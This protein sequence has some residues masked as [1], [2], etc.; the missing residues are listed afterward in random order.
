MRR[1]R[2]GR[3]RLG[4]RMLGS[5]RRKRMR[6]RLRLCGG[7][8]HRCWLERRPQHRRSTCRQCY[9]LLCSLLRRDDLVGFSPSVGVIGQRKF[10]HGFESSECTLATSIR[11][12]SLSLTSSGVLGRRSTDILVSDIPDDDWKEW[13]GRS[14]AGKGG[15]KIQ[16]LVV[17]SR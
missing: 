7:V 17:G 8:W 16:I 2:R 9:A 15:A 6:R 11:R 1:G 4:G 12:S 13:V 10:R 5:W 3:K 14:G